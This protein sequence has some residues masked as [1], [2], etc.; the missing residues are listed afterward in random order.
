MLKYVLKKNRPY[1]PHYN[2]TMYMLYVNSLFQAFLYFN[3]AKLRGS[4]E[5]PFMLLFCLIG[6][7]LC[8]FCDMIDLTYG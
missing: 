7:E 5:G 3:M 2:Y 1:Y 4:S 6:L 8:V